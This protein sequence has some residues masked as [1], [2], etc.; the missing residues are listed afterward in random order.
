M[1]GLGLSE[2]PVSVRN[3]TSPSSVFQIK[4]IIYS[5]LPLVISVV[6]ATCINY[7]DLNNSMLRGH[8]SVIYFRRDV[9]FLQ[10]K[11]N[12]FRHIVASAQSEFF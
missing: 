2:G 4:I 12:G 6:L 11:H 10:G 1:L 5:I 7:A 8:V 9:V 3:R